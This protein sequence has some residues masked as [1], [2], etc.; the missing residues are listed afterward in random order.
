MVKLCLGI[1]SLCTLIGFVASIT[2]EDK[3]TTGDEPN[4]RSIF[5][6][7]PIQ[8]VRPDDGHKRLVVVEEN[9]K[10]GCHL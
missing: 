3:V 6:D 7:Q 5:P 1:Y 9:L 2:L 8:L 10:V 4:K